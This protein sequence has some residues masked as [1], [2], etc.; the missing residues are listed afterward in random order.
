MMFLNSIIAKLLWIES[1]IEPSLQFSVHSDC[2]GG[3]A[4]TT[5]RRPAKRRSEK[6]SLPTGS[7]HRSVHRRFCYTLQ[8]RYYIGR[9]CT[10]RY[11]TL[12]RSYYTW[13]SAHAAAYRSE[14]PP[15]KFGYPTKNRRQ[16]Y[17]S[18]RIACPKNA[19]DFRRTATSVQ[20][21][22]SGEQAEQI[23]S[24]RFDYLNSLVVW[25][26]QCLPIQCCWREFPLI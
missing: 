20:R 9:Y 17:D 1:T 24:G 10:G 7:V 16:C 4:F 6:T 21:Q 26:G 13:R 19:F 11:Y 14:R 12:Q 3:C 18:E 5:E 2:L 25:T 15:K 8:W 23:D 22:A